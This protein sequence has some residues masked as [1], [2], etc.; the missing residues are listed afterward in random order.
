MP[1]SSYRSKDTSIDVPD[2]GLNPKESKK[3]KTLRV[4]ISA[5]VVI[6]DITQCRSLIN[7]TLI[8][9]RVQSVYMLQQAISSFTQL[10]NLNLGYLLLGYLLLFSD[11]KICI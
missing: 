2:I 8:G 10:M 4:T 9:V 1:D 7:L 3:L 5:N 11:K 6:I